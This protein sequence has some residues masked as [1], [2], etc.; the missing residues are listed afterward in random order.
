VT[1]PPSGEAVPWSF[2]RSLL[3]VRLDHQD[4]EVWRD[5]AL[6]SHRG[7]YGR[8]SPTTKKTAAPSDWGGRTHPCPREFFGEKCAGTDPRRVADACP[9]NPHPV[10][11]AYDGGEEYVR[12][13]HGTWTVN[14]RRRWTLRTSRPSEVGPRPH[15]AP[16]WVRLVEPAPPLVPIAISGVLPAPL[17]LAVRLVAR[18]SWSRARRGLHRHSCRAAPASAAV[19]SPRCY[20]PNSGPAPEATGERV[21]AA[22]IA[23]ASSWT[24]AR[25][26]GSGIC[27]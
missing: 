27:A 19:P 21:L 24:P 6:L 14:G 20:E 25:I 16:V 12:P 23:S 1:R 11:L 3:R 5:D 13:V 17:L 10:A 7:P 2:C 4:P 18:R 26:E 8:G 22:L 9:V 15:R